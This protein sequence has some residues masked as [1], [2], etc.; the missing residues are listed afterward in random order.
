MNTYTI[1]ING[2]KAFTSEELIAIRESI[3]TT[4]KLIDA[5][6]TGATEFYNSKLTEFSAIE[7]VLF[8]RR[9]F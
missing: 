2:F 9:A 8:D 5:T 7:Q 6:K 4:I 3:L 1:D